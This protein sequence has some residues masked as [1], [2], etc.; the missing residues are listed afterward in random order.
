MILKSPLV[1]SLGFGHFD[2]MLTD[3]DVMATAVEEWGP[4]LEGLTAVQRKEMGRVLGRGVMSHEM[5]G[6]HS[7]LKGNPTVIDAAKA[8]GARLKESLAA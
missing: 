6:G 7:P 4:Q 3:V 8:L 5:L 1:R 2:T